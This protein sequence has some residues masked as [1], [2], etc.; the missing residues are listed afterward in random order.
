MEKVVKSV[1][2]EYIY[3]AKPNQTTSDLALDACNNL[4]DGIGWDRT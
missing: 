4:I 2:L 3:K 1:G